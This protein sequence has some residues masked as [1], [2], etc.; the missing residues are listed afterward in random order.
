MGLRRDSIHMTRAIALPLICAVTALAAAGCG[1]SAGSGG[2][3]DPAS[4]VPASAP[5]YAEAA[6]QPTGE[7]RDDALAAAGKLLRTDD[8][9]GRL[10]RLIDDGLADD[11]GLTWEKD[12]APWL[13]EDAGVWASNLEAPEPSWAVIVATKDAEAAATALGRFR[14][15]DPDATYTN[16][17]YD[18]VDYAVDDERVA[19]GMVDDFVVIGTEDA[20]KRTA[21]LRDGGDALA[22]ADRYRT[23]VGDLGD[24]SLGHY[25]MDLRP[26]FEAALKQDP[27]TAAQLH[28][29]ESI[30]PFEKLG[31]ITG[32]FQADGEGMSLDTV[33]TGV[34]E[35][36]FRDLAKLWSGS[37][38]KLLAG[39]PAD[40]WGALAIPGL[41][42][43]AESTLNSFAGALGGAAVAAQVKQATGL[44]LSQD[45]FSWVGDVGGFVRGAD[46]ASLDGALVIQ[47]T[48]DAKARTAFGKLIGL[49]AKQ[50]AAVPKPV[51]VDGADAAFALPA[52]GADKPVVVA[53]GQGRVVVGYGVAAATA[54]LKGDGGLGG[55]EVYGDAK[56]VLGDDVSPSFLLSMPAVITLVDAMGQADADFEEARPYLD[57]LGSIA[58]GGATDDDRVESRIAVSLK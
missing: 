16:R 42:E 27:E 34:P 40:A 20:F 33:L 25:Y 30:V 18:G 35:G 49:I 4:L 51:Q 3:A 58:T 38:A 12:F 45:V 31:P 11:G 2:D 10:R 47:A 8:P 50:S 6:V 1:A 39:L 57:T 54:G 37:E 15:D 17:S 53:H 36:P 55:S 14:E 7:R 26:V 46:E 32:A 9:A 48:D 5:I 56:G 28:Q 24:D 29:I 52:T 43:A 21:D 23:A 13:G 19:N 44:D 41:G 22:D